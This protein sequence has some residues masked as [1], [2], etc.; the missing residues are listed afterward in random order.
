MYIREKELFN[1]FTGSRKRER[2]FLEGERDTGR[3]GDLIELVHPPS[4]SF[5]RGTRICSRVCVSGINCVSNLRMGI[6]LLLGWPQ[7]SYRSYPECLTWPGSMD[8]I[9][10]I[11]R[12]FRLCSTRLEVEFFQ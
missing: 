6:E 10:N 7:Y 3:R 9:D 1:R 8:S 2:D 12:R 5:T 4:D 11:D